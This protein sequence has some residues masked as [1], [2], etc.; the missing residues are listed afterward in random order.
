MKKVQ[1]A[2]ARMEKK[3]YVEPRLEK[4][5]KLENVTQ[6]VDPVVTGALPA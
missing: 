2:G 3:A 5:Q 6:G 4:A 1:E